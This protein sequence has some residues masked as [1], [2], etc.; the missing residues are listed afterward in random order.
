MVSG[1]E[2]ALFDWLVV[3]Q[4][5]HPPRSVA[6]LNHRNHVLRWKKPPP[7]DPSRPKLVIYHWD[8][9]AGLKR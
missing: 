1:V 3:Q 7:K 9:Q 4:E 6:D 5:E 2:E 8:D